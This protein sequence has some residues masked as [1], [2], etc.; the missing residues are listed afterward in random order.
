[1]C[2]HRQT[3]YSQ[4]ADTDPVSRRTPLLFLNVCLR[5]RYKPT[6][7][8]ETPGRSPGPARPKG[9]G[10]TPC[11]PA[12]GG[13]P[14]YWGS[15][16]PAGPPASACAVGRDVLELAPS[17]GGRWA[18]ASPSAPRWRRQCPRCA[19]QCAV[20]QTVEQYRAERQREHRRHRPCLPQASQTRASAARAAGPDP[21]AA[22]SGHCMP[23]PVRPSEGGGLG[24]SAKG[25]RPSR[26]APP[27]FPGGPERPL[28]WAL[29]G[30]LP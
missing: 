29:E 3:H 9:Q 13:G 28:P 21:A 10:Q 11:W 4:I 20:W 7:S 8:L 2:V 5:V 18:S 15:R 30:P 22:L 26:G 6:G 14:H 1:M 25:P 27:L 16:V 17:V 23:T 12:R 19:G 24:L